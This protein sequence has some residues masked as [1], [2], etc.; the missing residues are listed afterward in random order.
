[1]II[2][3]T[4]QLNENSLYYTDHFI[5]YSA[6]AG[7]MESSS[8]LYSVL[9]V[10]R[11]ASDQEIR[12]AYHKKAR[13]HHPDRNGSISDFTEQ[14]EMP[15]GSI[16]DI[17]R[18]QQVQQ[19]YE[20]L[21]DVE[22]RADYDRKVNLKPHI[23]SASTLNNENVQKI[24]SG[25]FNKSEGSLKR[26][27]PEALAQD[28][29]QIKIPRTLPPISDLTKKPDS[30]PSNS[31]NTKFI[32]SSPASYQQQHQP[33]P[34]STQ[35]DSG[36]T[37]RLSNK[38]G[39]YAIP[40]NRSMG[41]INLASL[42]SI[43]S[44]SGVFREAPGEDL[45]IHT[46]EKISFAESVEGCKKEIKFTKVEYCK[47]CST[48]SRSNFSEY[49]IDKAISQACICGGLGMR[50]TEGVVTV[51]I[52][53]GVV[54]GC[55]KRL[56]GEGNI[57]S[58][59]QKGDVILTVNVEH[60]PFLRRL[61]QIDVECDL[62]ISFYHLCIGATLTIPSIRGTVRVSKLINTVILKLNI[63]NLYY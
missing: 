7:W 12:A 47:I 11:D 10:A 59:G 22:T 51:K 2:L 61:N 1:M 41:N 40:M 16:P 55:K 18:F 27:A 34:S 48:A 45:T 36:S 46:T 6:F 60:H 20:V 9:G 32:H 19:A 57:S 30:P 37:T 33:S 43:G 39:N 21:K 58:R 4:M 13:E 44:M 17:A 63:L 50:K 8:C 38:S 15:T 23:I 31:Q 56:P 26:M 42:A 28:M 54:D 35:H 24:L 52:P 5:F 14:K 25:I 29:P 3:L 53:A 49:S 62:P